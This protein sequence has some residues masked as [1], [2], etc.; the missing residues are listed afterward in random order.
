MSI[1]E[2]QGMKWFA[3]GRHDTPPTFQVVEIRGK[4]YTDVQFTVDRLTRE[5][6]TMTAPQRSRRESS[7]QFRERMTEGARTHAGG[8]A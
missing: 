4:T 2:E 6:W 5:G 7:A 1:R 3:T 8:N